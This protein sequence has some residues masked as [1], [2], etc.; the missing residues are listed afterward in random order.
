MAEESMVMPSDSDSEIFSEDEYNLQV[1]V[2]V[3]EAEG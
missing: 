3:T 1:T 2:A